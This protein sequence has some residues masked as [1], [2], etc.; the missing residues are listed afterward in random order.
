MMQVLH[1]FFSRIYVVYLSYND[2][3]TKLYNR[4]K[5]IKTIE[6]YTTH[7]LSRIGT[8]YMDLNGLKETND[9]LGHEAEQFTK[10]FSKHSYRTGGD[11]FVVLHANIDKHEFYRKVETLVEN[12]KIMI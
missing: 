5:Y 10:E 12:L 8:A 1:R 6:Y 7:P 11:E 4:N 2:V 9:K 3:L